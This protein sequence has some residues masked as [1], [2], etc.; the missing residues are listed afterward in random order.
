MSILT[1]CGRKEAEQVEAKNK[2]AA[3]SAFMHQGN[4]KVRKWGESGFVGFSS[5]DLKPAGSARAAAES[6]EASNAKK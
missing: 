4:G 1:G 6:S 5:K 3:A 2:A